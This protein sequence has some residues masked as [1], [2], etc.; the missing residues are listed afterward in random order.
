MRMQGAEVMKADK[1]IGGGGG[2]VENVTIFIC[3]DK[4]G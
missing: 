3:G 1:N 2:R 4:D